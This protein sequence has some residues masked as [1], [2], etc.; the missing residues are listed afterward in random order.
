MSKAEDTS[1]ETPAGR[2][3]A[4]QR[5][6]KR[7]W[8]RF[9][10]G[11]GFALYA[12]AVVLV[13]MAGWAAGVNVLQSG[14]NSDVAA[15]VQAAGSIAAIAG[16][17][18]IAQSEARRARRVRRE[19]NEEAAWHVR[20]AIKQ[21]Q[22]ESHIIAAE[23]VN[24]TT[25]IEESDVREW[26]QRAATSAIELNALVGRIDH[27]HPAVIH[28]VSNAKVL[29][30]ELVGDLEYLGRL[31]DK[32]KQPERIIITRIVA[33]HRALLELITHYDARMRGIK[34]ALDEGDDALPIKTWA[35]WDP[36]RVE[37]TANDE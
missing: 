24:R 5:R 17:T 30:D 29:V 16:A 3:Q 1:I 4:L 36:D 22:F 27:V 19:Q 37:G 7:I 20:F 12:I 14:W 28:F 21:A 35:P 25:P 31:L 9:S 11:L 15:W 8:R 2:Q 33:P 18:W 23:L 13:G 6:L 26:R 32:N 10:D 34:L